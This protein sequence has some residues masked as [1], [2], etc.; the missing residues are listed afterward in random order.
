MTVNLI[1]YKDTTFSSVNGSGHII[2]LIC[3]SS[4]VARSRGIARNAVGI[5]A[6]STKLDDPIHRPHPESL[7]AFTSQQQQQQHFDAVFG[8][9]MSNSFE[10]RKALQR[11]ALLQ[12]GAWLGESADV[13]Y[14]SSA[15]LTDFLS[16][17]GTNGSGS[18]NSQPILF[19]LNSGVNTYMRAVNK[20]PRSFE[21]E[22]WFNTLPICARTFFNDSLCADPSRRPT[23]ISA[24]ASL[25]DGGWIDKMGD[26]TELLLAGSVFDLE[27]NELQANSLRHDTVETSVSVKVEE[28]R[29]H[30]RKKGLDCGECVIS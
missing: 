15:L 29:I 17:N 30:K 22:P 19:P 21:M 2:S 3:K 16:R 28:F 23:A 8:G 5:A 10:S 1:I 25:R 12:S 9:L 20:T 14:A 18:R 6:R 7:S 24:I 11:N 27:T 13:W 26:V 4:E